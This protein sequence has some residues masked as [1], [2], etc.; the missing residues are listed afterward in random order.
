MAVLRDVL[1]GGRQ[2]GLEPALD[3]AQLRGPL[4]LGGMH[5]GQRADHGGASLPHLVAHEQPN[6]NTCS[7]GDLGVAPCPLGL[8]LVPQLQAAKPLPSRDPADFKRYTQYVPC[9]AESSN[10]IPVAPGLG[11]PLPPLRRVP[12]AP[13]AR[14]SRAASGQ[15]HTTESQA[16]RN[17]NHLADKHVVNISN[18]LSILS[19]IEIG[20]CESKFH[21]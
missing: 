3:L 18:S 14:T 2:P 4:R 17:P 1:P 6:L 5:R 20:F 12:L 15:V 9:V 16:D 13:L 7:A 21:E 8:Q 10:G 11:S 19:T